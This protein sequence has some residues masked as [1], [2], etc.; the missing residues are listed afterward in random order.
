MN[1]ITITFK[2]FNPLYIKKTASIIYGVLF[3]LDRLYNN[4]LL[5]KVLYIPLPKKTKKYTFIK[6]PHIDKKSREQ[7]EWNRYKGTVTILLNNLYPTAGDSLI[8]F[9]KNS[10]PSYIGVQL[11]IDTIFC[12]YL[13]NKPV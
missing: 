2:S 1:Q 13:V 3:F 8:F 5:Q 10:S 11:K 7:F 4:N 6:S 9:L 12:S